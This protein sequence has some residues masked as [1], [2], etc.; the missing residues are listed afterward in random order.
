MK[1]YLLFAAVLLVSAAALSADVSADK[2]DEKTTP[3]G[4]LLWHSYSNYSAM[5]SRL[6][7]RSPEGDIQEITGDFVHAMNGSFGQSP[8]QIVFMAIDQSADEWDIFLYD[9]GSIV[10]LTKASGF[11]NED[12]KWSPDGQEIIYK[13]GHWDHSM[14][15]FV[16]NLALMDIQSGAVTELTDDSAEEAMPCFSSDG[17]SLYYASYSD[18]IGSICRMD[19]LTRRAEIVYSVQGVTAYYPITHGDMLCFTKWYSAENHCDQIMQ[20][21]GQQAVPLPFNSAEY[22]CSDACPLDGGKMIYS[23]TAKG[24]YDLWYYDGEKSVLLTD[25][26]S[27]KNELGADFFALQEKPADAFALQNWLLTK[28]DAVLQ[29]DWDQ[30]HD[31]VLNVIDL[32]I[33]KRQRMNHGPQ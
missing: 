2:Q 30:N 26:C 1:R 9:S 33:L 13:R 12:P 14:N 29:D 4:W 18:G 23:S 16:Y 8:E 17:D 11:R 27:D 20:Y 15:G 3:E 6:F 21:D 22:D 24:N 31:G 19:M 5:D 28:A 25:C 10:N 7:V 32:T